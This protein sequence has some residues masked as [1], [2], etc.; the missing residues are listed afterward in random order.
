MV[1]LTS[2]DVDI[3][4]RIGKPAD[5]SLRA[6]KLLSNHTIVC[7]SPAYLKKHGKPTVPDELT[8]HNCLMLSQKR[9]RTYWYFKNAYE[10][11][12]VLIKGNI[13][14]TGG[15]PLLEAAEKGAGII[16]L[17]NWMVS[18]SVSEGKLEVILDDWESSLHGDTSGE[19]LA[20]F[21]NSKYMNPALRAF[22]D[23]LAENIT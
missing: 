16:H 8:K 6:R 4:I 21:Q 1:D 19:I 22:I 11:H 15:T 3:A 14:S 5:S 7:A 9:Q 23:F 17:A 10:R 13:S 2:E 12:K 20:V 18:S